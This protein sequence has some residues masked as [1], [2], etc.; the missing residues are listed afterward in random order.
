M[1]GWKWYAALTLLVSAMFVIYGV[2][3]WHLLK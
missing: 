3:V 2:A 1:D